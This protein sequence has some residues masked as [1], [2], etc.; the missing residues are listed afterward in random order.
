MAMRAIWSGSLSFGL[1]NIPIKL[2]S[3]SEER[4]LKFHMLHKD[5][6]SPIR[7][8]KIC[9]KEGKEIPYE[10]IVKGYE[11][12]EGDYV[13][14][15]DEDFQSANLKK[16]KA[17]DIFDFADQTEIDSKF[18]DSPYFL[19]PTKGAEKP[20]A[21]LREALKRSGKV[22]IGK[23][24]LRQKEILCAIKPEGNTLLLNRLRFQDQLRESSG[25]KIPSDV[26]LKEKE[27]ELAL[28][29]IE[30]L[31]GPFKPEDYKDTYTAEL[32]EVIK[33]KIEGKEV[34]VHGEEPVPTRVT[35]LMEILRKSLK[36]K[37]KSRQ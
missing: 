25:L 20:Y 10:D 37:V 11:Y 18:F 21:L 16:N 17:V 32:E 33:Q 14:L 31:S 8:A 35:D 15:A 27:I 3:G 5:D 4:E 24:V 34:T 6:L 1:V 28:R 30:E 9:A 23:F 29:L 13:I 19:E 7:Y 26:E 36:T 2:Y 12:S 22:G